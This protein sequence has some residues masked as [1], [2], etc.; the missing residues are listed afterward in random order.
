MKHAASV[1]VM[2]CFYLGAQLL[3]VY[4]G[5]TL[6]ERISADEF[7]AAV[8]DPESAGSSALI[9]VYILA[10]TGVLLVLIRYRLEFVIRGL[11][12][13]S[14][15]V[16]LTL[17][18]WAL[19]GHWGVS[20]LMALLGLLLFIWQR[21]NPYVTN[22]LLVGTI[23][24]FGGWLGASL[25]FTPSLLLVLVLAGY[26]LVAVFLTK[27]MVTLA[28]A[29]RGSIAFMLRVPTERSELGLGTGDLAIPLT[30]TV[31]VLGHY[32][33]LSI[34][35]ATLMGGFIGMAALLYHVTQRKKT[36]LP[37]LPPI[38]GG[39]LGGFLAGQILLFFV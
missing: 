1:I 14:V 25:G 35:L 3:G 21:E 5:A 11:L 31:S 2:L 26:D 36:T 19:T 17:T 29:S 28:E 16:G 7:V 33:S 18:V 4:V 15:G 37:A 32:D 27:H 22:Y 38:A 10:M 12:L 39:L 6:L 8:E 9:F 24:G 23:A 20:A 30:F 13:L 34:A